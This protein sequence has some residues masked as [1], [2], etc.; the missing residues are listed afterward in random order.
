[1]G[2]QYSVFFLAFSECTCIV[3]MRGQTCAIIT[4]I[5]AM[6]G[7]SKWSTIKRQKGLNDAKKGAIFTKL[8]KA[9]S[10]AVKEGGADPG[11]NVKLR[12]AIEKARESNM[13]KDNVE[14]AIERGTGAGGASLQEMV[15]EGYGPE[16][17]PIIVEAAT[18]NKNR[19][20]QEM[21]NLF[22]RG[23]GTMGS[24]GSVSFQFE[25][26]GQILAEKG[27]NPEERMLQLIDLGVEDIEEVEDGIEVYTR[28]EELHKIRHTLEEAGIAVKEAELVFCPRDPMPV[29]DADK[30]AKI[31]KFLESLDDHDDVQKVYAGVDL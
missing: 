1:L 3:K 25:R 17:V 6:S 9:I 10:I 14:H 15:Y 16:G 13:P 4:Y 18:D 29:Q 30:S 27:T 5:F 21:K 7:H 20:A 8:A 31:V 26:A 23:G 11:G 2:V 22:E 28:P 24:P 19:T 12:F